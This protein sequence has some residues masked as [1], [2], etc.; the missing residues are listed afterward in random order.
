MMDILINLMGESSIYMYR[1]RY[2]KYIL[3]IYN[4]KYCIIQVKYFI[5]LYVNCISIKLEKI[6]DSQLNLNLRLKGI[7]F[8]ICTPCKI[9]E[10]LFI[11]NLKFEFNWCSVFYLQPYTQRPRRKTRKYWWAALC[12]PPQ[13]FHIISF[14]SYLTVS[15]LYCSLAWVWW[16]Q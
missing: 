15:V 2:I 14:I 11:V 16:W 5:I 12:I 3:H 4:H 9:L 1:Y 8:N 7:I 13:P 10:I 6:Q